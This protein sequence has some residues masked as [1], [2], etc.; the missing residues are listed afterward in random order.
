M[1][2]QKQKM[3]KKKS[4]RKKNKWKKNKH[5]NKKKEMNED[6]KQK[7]KMRNKHRNK[8]KEMNKNKKSKRR[9]LVFYAMLNHYL[10]YRLVTSHSIVG[11]EEVV[12]HCNQG[13]TSC[14]HAALVVHRV[15]GRLNR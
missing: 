6:G 10:G 14:S 3:R 2:K 7:Q 5:R 15:N 11:I 1:D 4:N 13:I 12:L 8:K 9:Y